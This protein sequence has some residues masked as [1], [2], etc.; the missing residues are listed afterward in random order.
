M[1]CLL[2]EPDELGEGP[3]DQ[4]R[5]ARIEGRRRRHAEEILRAEAGDR[6][7]VGLVGGRIGSARVLALD[8]EAL[9]LEVLLDR[10]P[11]AKR[12]LEL[13]LALPRPPVFRRLLSTIAS[14]GITRLVVAGTAR[15]EGSFWQ[16]HVLDAEEIRARLLLGL[17]QAR[18]TVLPQVELHRY[19]EPLVDEVLA[20]RIA[21]RRALLAHPGAP[22]SCPHAVDGPITLFVGPEGGFVDYEVSRLEGIGFESVDLGPRVLRVEPVVPLL[23]GRLCP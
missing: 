23:V 22:N 14:L 13:V 17:E 18:D 5:R 20:P 1:N 6:L 11:P 8:A 21:G 10:D 15:T 12:P 2:L 16:S 3:P 19:F 7:R 9:E 4:P